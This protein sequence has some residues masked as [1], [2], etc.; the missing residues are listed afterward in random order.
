MASIYSYMDH[1]FSTL[2][3]YSRLYASFSRVLAGVLNH[4]SEKD[5]LISI[6]YFLFKIKLNLSSSSTLRI[7]Y[8][9]HFHSSCQFVMS[10]S[11][12]FTGPVLSLVDP[13]HP[14]PGYVETCP[15][16]GHVWACLDRVYV[17]L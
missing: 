1:N 6:M 16:T 14:Q 10:G 5:L 13:P 2:M 11:C 7:Q 4:T 17:I 9:I 12:G 8:C 3:R 15:C